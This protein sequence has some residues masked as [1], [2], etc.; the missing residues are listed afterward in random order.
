MA[1][2]AKNNGASSLTTGLAGIVIG[3]AGASAAMFL[4][5]EKNRKKMKKTV[6]DFKE[7]STAVVN[8]VLGKGENLADKTLVTASEL[9]NKGEDSSDRLQKGFKEEAPKAK[10]KLEMDKAKK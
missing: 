6:D 4:S 2:K 8:E 5:E 10:N 7:K 1:D 9:R 3:A